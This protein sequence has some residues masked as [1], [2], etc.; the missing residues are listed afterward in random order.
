[1]SLDIKAGNPVMLVPR[2]AKSCH[3]LVADLGN[4]TVANGFVWEGTPN[5]LT[6]SAYSKSRQRAQPQTDFGKCSVKKK[7]FLFRQRF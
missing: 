4:L 7:F 1:M 6:Y 5:T 3:M 2:S